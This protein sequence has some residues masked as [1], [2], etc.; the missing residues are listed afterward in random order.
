MRLLQLQIYTEL[1]ELSTA[2]KEVSENLDSIVKASALQTRVE[3]LIRQI[4]DMQGY[5]KVRIKDQLI[6]L[7]KSAD[8]ELYLSS[9][10]VL[11]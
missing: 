6:Y 3:R 9:F 2:V 8:L 11:S 5:V 7:I 1:R 10:T 4:T